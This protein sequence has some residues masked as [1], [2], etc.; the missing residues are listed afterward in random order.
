[1]QRSARVTLALALLSGVAA[2]S[3][4]GPTG[5]LAEN[6]QMGRGG[7]RNGTTL[8]ASKTATGFDEQ[9][10]EYDWSLTKKVNEIMDEHMHPEPSTSTTEIVPGVVKW[11]D[12]EI[13]AK[14]TLVSASDVSGV[15]GQVCVT[16]GGGVATEGL[17]IL[18]VVQKK[19]GSGQ[20]TD[21]V[22]APVDVSAKPVLGPGESYCYPYEIR[23]DGASGVQYRNTARVT[24][25]N[26]SGHLGT[27]FGPAF[28]GGGVKADFTMPANPTVTTKDAEATLSEELVQACA[29]LW[30]ALICTGENRFRFAK[31]LTRDTTFVT[32]TV[33]LHNFVVCGETLSFTNN[34]SLT[35]SGVGGV[36]GERHT[37]SA[38][39]VVTTGNCASE[40]PKG[41][42]VTADYWRT[43][44]WPAH[45]LW[46]TTT[47]ENWP[48]NEWFYFFDSG[49]HWS[50][51]LRAAANGSS[52]IA[53][54][55]EYIAASLNQQNGAYV[56]PQ[57][58]DALVAAYNYFLASPQERANVSGSTLA[59]LTSLLRSYNAG[60]LETRS[61][62]P[63][64]SNS[65][66]SSQSKKG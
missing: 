60:A 5:P 15:R 34:A 65:N 17:A 23:F 40:K 30:P 28:N 26:H 66:S 59:S 10:T 7:G 47:L 21:H 36:P 18:D 35:E 22:S 27:P 49:K 11:I 42:T 9:R 8:S 12:Y 24:I 51:M 55:H 50:E 46:P 38:T 39:I 45:P 61:C 31:Q 29:A 6:A 43:H 57:V 4:D 58:R 33:D 62:R 41:C 14:R 53:L 37:A 20:F 13:S 54:A 16:N 52:Y 2:C 25:L 56:P 48:E 44:A 1:M 19:A 3:H 32:H 64:N 63:G